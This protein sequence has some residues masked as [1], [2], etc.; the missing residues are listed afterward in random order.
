MCAGV[1][2]VTA[3]RKEAPDPA[4][5]RHYRDAGDE[6]GIVLLY[7]ALK[8][9]RRKKSRADRAKQAAVEHQPS[10]CVRNYCGEKTYGLNVRDYLIQRNGDVEQFRTYAAA[11]EA[12]GVDVSGIL[13]IK[14]IP[15]CAEEDK[16]EAADQT[17][18]R[19]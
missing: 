12:E 8:K 10:L 15:A 17:C 5:A 6:C 7:V 4:E 16:K 18:G 2:T 14:L 19:H 1:S 3:P 9:A 13:G 11:Q